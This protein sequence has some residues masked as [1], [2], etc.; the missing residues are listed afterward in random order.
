MANRCKIEAEDDMTGFFLL[1]SIIMDKKNVHESMI[2]AARVD[3]S[4]ASDPSGG[5]PK[6]NKRLF[7][8]GWGVA[9]YTTT[10]QTTRHK[11]L[12]SPFPWHRHRP[13]G[14]HRAEEEEE[15]QPPSPAPRWQRPPVSRGA[16]LPCRR[17]VHQS[18][19]FPGGACYVVASP[20]TRKTLTRNIRMRVWFYQ[21]G[22][23]TLDS[24]LNSNRN[25]AAPPP[26]RLSSN[27]LSPSAMS[28]RERQA[29][30]K[31]IATLTR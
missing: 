21:T 12:R 23:A 25:N 2:S 28:R 7:S 29:S 30:V 9:T 22:M 4:K 1:H 5:L 10:S 19:V 11:C 8:R 20:T 24:R 26:R 17:I 27:L 3:S 14:C 16:L 15:G 31:P 6:E 13:H 18:A